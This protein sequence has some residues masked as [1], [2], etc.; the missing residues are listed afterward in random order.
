VAIPAPS[1]IIHV[2]VP[3]KWSGPEIEAGDLDLE[4]YE[5]DFLFLLGT[6]ERRSE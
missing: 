4:S 1:T 2:D 6:A 5:C 3:E